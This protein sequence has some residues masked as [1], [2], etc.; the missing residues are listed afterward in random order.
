MRYVFPIAWLFIVPFVRA[1]SFG[2]PAILEGIGITQ[3]IGA[4]VPLDIPFTD[5][6]GRSVHLREYSGKPVLL[7]LVYYQCPSLCNLILNGVLRATKRLDFAAGDQFEIVAVS[8]D[9]REDHTIALPKML[10]YVAEYGRSGGTNGWHFLTGVDSSIQQ[11]ADSVGF[12]YRFDSASNQYVH[13]SGIIL[14]TPDGRVS[15]YFYGINYPARDL[16]F[17]LMEASGGKLGSPID[18]VQLFCFHYDPSTGKYAPAIM[19]VLR[20]AGLA[21]LGS[22]LFFVTAMLVRERR[23]FRGRL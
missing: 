10:G 1:D 15:R 20:A 5:E 16:K 9:P 2:R 18:Q 6:H 4:T 21:T 14:L 13:A 22:L 19:H 11:L 8:F 12:H 7:A 3:Q 17:G 23:L